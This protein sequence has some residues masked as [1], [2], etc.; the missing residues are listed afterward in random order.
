[1]SQIVSR[2]WKPVQRRG[3]ERYLQLTIL[4]FA[5]SVSVTR[6]I[7]Q[8]TGY[9]QL[10]NQTLHIAHV[11]YGG[12]F[13]YAASLLPLLYANRWAYT[14]SAILSGLGV[15][16]FI[17][18][19]GKFITQ[20]NDYFFP[21]AAPII[22]AFFLLTVLLYQRTNKKIQLDVRSSL[23][24]VIEVLQEV[25]DH[26]LETDELEEM[27]TRLNHIIKEVQSPHYQS[28]ATE[29]QHFVES[30]ALE[31]VIEKPNLFDKIITRWS[32]FEQS[33]LSENRVKVAIIIS[34][35]L[36]GVPR[37]LQLLDF[38]QIAQN[39]ILREAYLKAIADEIPHLSKNGP[40]WA[41]VLIM[42]DGLL[43]FLLSLGGALILIGRKNWG[44][45]TASIALVIKLVALNLL[46]FYIEQ[47]ATIITAGY[48]FI[49]LQGIYFYQRKYIKNQ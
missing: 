22:Y 47:F 2:I 49:I 30:D 20:T 25:L 14:W 11:L 44:T 29:L 37:F 6:L 5:A 42:F 19:V 18:E 27:K 45:E 9:P 15:G 38:S 7:L 31:T 21:A 13:L 1:M 41:F 24:T 26:S 36:L 40:M 8:L 23:Y 12:V 10:G 46:L 17:D 34:L 48:Q 43:G 28:L 32:W 39:P 33:Y 4:S 16:L 3:A 35:V